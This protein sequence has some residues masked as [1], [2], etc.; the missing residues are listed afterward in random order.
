[1][2]VGGGQ[3]DERDHL[4]IPALRFLGQPQRLLVVIDRLLVPGQ[5]ALDGGQGVEGV[6][7]ESL[8][9]EQLHTLQ[10]A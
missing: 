7:S 10:T 9:A 1:V 4:G 6:Q 3:P 5:A 2:L 8:A